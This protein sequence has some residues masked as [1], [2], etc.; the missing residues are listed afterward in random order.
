MAKASPS[1]STA[2]VGRA[3]SALFHSLPAS[4]DTF[5]PIHTVPVQDRHF[6][7]SGALETFGR[8]LLDASNSQKIE[9]LPTV[10][11]G[12]ALGNPESDMQPPGVLAVEGMCAGHLLLACG[13]DCSS[14]KSICSVNW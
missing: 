11:N 13:I 8:Q 14:E 10:C 4:L 9:F 7:P 12:T 2:A 1:P 5:F 6:A 3:A